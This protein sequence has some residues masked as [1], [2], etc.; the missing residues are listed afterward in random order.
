M[1]IYRLYFL[2]NFDCV[3]IHRNKDRGIQYFI[4]R[5]LNFDFFC[6]DNKLFFPIEKTRGNYP[7]IAM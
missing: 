3:I 6:R 4:E 2:Q 1:G 5:V 7:A